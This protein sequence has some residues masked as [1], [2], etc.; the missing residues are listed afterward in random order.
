MLSLLGLGF[1]DICP[2]VNE[3]LRFFILNRIAPGFPVLE[4]KKFE[5]CAE[6]ESPKECFRASFLAIITMKS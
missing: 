4:G 3:V 5:S 2:H 1:L 6:F